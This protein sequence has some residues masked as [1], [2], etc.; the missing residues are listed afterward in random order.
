MVLL[1][2]KAGNG[3][4]SVKNWANVLTKNYKKKDFALNFYIFF[5][6]TFDFHKKWYVSAFDCIKFCL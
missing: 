5:I 2:H 4:K 6:Q 1:S 3:Y